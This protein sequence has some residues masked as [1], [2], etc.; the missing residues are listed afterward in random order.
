[1]SI[2]TLQL[3]LFNP[4]KHPTPEPNYPWQHIFDWMPEIGGLA[5]MHS[6]ILPDYGYCYGDTVRI[7]SINGNQVVCTVESQYD[8][9]FW[10]NGTTYHC[11]LMDLWPIPHLL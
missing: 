6:V 7:N 10:K 3:S 1:M 8:N 9:A 11:H 4:T 2:K 5:Q